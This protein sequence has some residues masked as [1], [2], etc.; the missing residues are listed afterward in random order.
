MPVVDG[1][2]GEDQPVVLG[3]FERAHRVSQT[4]EVAMNAK[5]HL[6]GIV[7]GLIGPAGEELPLVV[8]GFPS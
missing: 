3:T 4:G 2:A 1:G 6:I 7:A 5:R 8:D